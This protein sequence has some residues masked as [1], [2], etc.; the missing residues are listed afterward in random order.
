MALSINYI[1]IELILNNKNVSDRTEIQRVPLFG[2]L[3]LV[4]EIASVNAQDL[5]P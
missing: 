2:I 1:C 3:L 4:F 5:E